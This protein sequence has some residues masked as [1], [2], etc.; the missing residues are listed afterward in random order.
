MAVGSAA[1]CQAPDAE[2]VAWAVLVDFLKRDLS[3]VHRASIL[4]VACFSL[5]LAASV[6]EG[7]PGG[8]PGW[9][10]GG[11][12][13]HM[14]KMQE[15]R[16]VQYRRLLAEARQPISDCTSCHDEASWGAGKEPRRRLNK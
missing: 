4:A 1:R 14:R 3:M 10:A 5:L 9:P 2:R 7:F 12:E 6:S 13:E 15:E 11:M 8:H 16:P